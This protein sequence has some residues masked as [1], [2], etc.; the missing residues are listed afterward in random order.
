MIKFRK[1]SAFLVALILMAGCA[2]TYEAEPKRYQEPR[3]TEE[4]PIDLKV[5]RVEVIS[6]FTPSFT[7][8]ESSI[9]FFTI[10]YPS[11]V[12]SEVYLLK[13]SRYASRVP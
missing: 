11:V 10:R 5:N 8:G 13:L 4:A 9:P 7:R 12:I 3:F 6:E 1:I 2:N